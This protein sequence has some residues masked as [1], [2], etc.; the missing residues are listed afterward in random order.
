LKTKFILDFAQAG[1]RQES[2]FRVRI[3]QGLDKQG[4][5]AWMVARGES[6]D[7]LAANGYVS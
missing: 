3:L 7:G 4:E 5:A 2:D 6:F 1:H